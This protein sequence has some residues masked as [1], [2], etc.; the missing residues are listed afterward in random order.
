RIAWRASAV[1]AAIQAAVQAAIQASASS[2]AAASSRAALGAVEGELSE[3]ASQTTVRSH[4]DVAA[5]RSG[6]H[7][8]FR[9]RDIHADAR[10]AG[11]LRPRRESVEGGRRLS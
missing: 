4:R 11:A 7:L 9:A 2:A 5:R 8:A 10:R 1:D 3:A 6:Q